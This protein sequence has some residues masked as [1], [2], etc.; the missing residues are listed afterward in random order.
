MNTVSTSLTIILE[1]GEDGFWI[2]TIP[3]VS[4][5]LSQGRTKADARKNVLMAME[6]LIAARRE[7][8]HRDRF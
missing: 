4:G 3:E 6:E 1:K 5:A 2:A 8:A 7:M